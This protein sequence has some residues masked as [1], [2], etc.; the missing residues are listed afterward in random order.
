MIEGIS[1]DTSEIKDVDLSPH[2]FRNA[3]HLRLLKIF[4]PI[5]R[6]RVNLP[7]GLHSLPDAL[8]CLSWDAYPSKSLPSD[9][10]PENLVELRMPNSQVE[11]LW[12]GVRVYFM[13]WMYF[14][15]FLFL[16]V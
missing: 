1:L 4:G 2:V 3:Y 13:F 11:R 16:T 5:H 6:C 12:N 10:A 7:Q 15:V 14:V 9:F 8:R